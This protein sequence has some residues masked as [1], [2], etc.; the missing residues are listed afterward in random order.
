[1]KLSSGAQFEGGA[2]GVFGEMET[3]R[4]SRMVVTRVAEVFDQPVMQREYEIVGA[5]GTVMLLRVQPT[6]CDVG[7]PR[8]R[9]LAFGDSRLCAGAAHERHCQSRR[10]ERRCL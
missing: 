10:P 3:F 7:V 1:M 9:H 4:Q 6:R 2:L 8:K 5:G